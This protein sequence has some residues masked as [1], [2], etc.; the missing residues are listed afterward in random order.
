VVA[1][2]IVLEVLWQ[3]CVAQ[4]G[5]GLPGFYQTCFV[6]DIFFIFVYIYF[7]NSMS[8]DNQYLSW[9]KYDKAKRE[10]LYKV[11]SAF[12]KVFLLIIYYNTINIL[13]KHV[14]K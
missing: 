11:N 3:D 8:L 7:P 2:E 5:F 9:L 10:L 4:R 6:E 14:L 13:H 1:S 12:K